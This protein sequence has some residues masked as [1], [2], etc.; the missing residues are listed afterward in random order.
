M[1]V[2]AEKKTGGNLS[3]SSPLRVVGPNE[4]SSILRR[5]MSKVRARIVEWQINI[6]LVVGACVFLL[7]GVVEYFQSV[8]GIPAWASSW[9]IALALVSLRMISLWIHPPR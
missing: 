9:I 4:G 5:T 2:E 8:H 1:I 6:A 7:L 3:K